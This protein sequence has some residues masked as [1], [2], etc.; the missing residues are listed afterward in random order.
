[1]KLEGGIL[2]HWK[3]LNVMRATRLSHRLSSNARVYWRRGICSIV[4]AINCD[5][6]YRVAAWLSVLLSRGGSRA[7]LTWQSAQL[8]T[9]CGRYATSCLAVRHPSRDMTLQIWSQCLSPVTT[10][11]LKFITFCTRR[12]CVSVQNQYWLSAVATTRN[13]MYWFIIE[14]TQNI[15]PE[16]VTSYKAAEG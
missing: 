15:R 13:F 5:I 12:S 6:F 8:R 14:P 3:L 10:R 2:R 4:V 11:A 16:Y 9:P 7:D 1:M